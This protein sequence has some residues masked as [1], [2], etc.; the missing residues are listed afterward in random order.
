MSGNLQ[1]Q[2][3]KKMNEILEKVIKVSASKKGVLKA[4]K[5]LR[6]TYWDY[7]TSQWEAGLFASDFD[8]WLEHELEG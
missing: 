5:A 2:E 1:Q 8:T 4:F 3:D 6:A 7:C